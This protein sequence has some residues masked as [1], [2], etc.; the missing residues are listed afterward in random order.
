MRALSFFIEHTARQHRFDW[1]LGMA[2]V[3]FGASF[4]GCPDVLA[5]KI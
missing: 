1:Q 2:V 5:G 4:F 3:H